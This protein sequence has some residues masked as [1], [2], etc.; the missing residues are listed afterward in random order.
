MNS[1]QCIIEVTSELLVLNELVHECIMGTGTDNT[2]GR[3]RLAPSRVYY[4]SEFIMK[5][6]LTTL[7]WITGARVH[8]VGD[9]HECS[10]DQ[11]F[12]MQVVQVP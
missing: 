7:G 6:I 12:T 4:Q 1:D 5:K 2:R 3:V 8:Y 9:R 11:N 10:R